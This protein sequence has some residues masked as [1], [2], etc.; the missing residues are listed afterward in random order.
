[1]IGEFGDATFPCDCACGDYCDYFVFW[2]VSQKLI[3]FS[4]G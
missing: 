4:V 2:G 3:L 1:M